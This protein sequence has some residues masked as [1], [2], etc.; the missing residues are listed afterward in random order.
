[1]T[2]S[3][4]MTSVVTSEPK[5]VEAGKTIHSELRCVKTGWEVTGQVCIHHT[6]GQACSY[7]TALVKNVESACLGLYVSQMDVLYNFNI[8]LQKEQ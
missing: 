6:M 5:V 2:F 1:M 4:L 3:Y 8:T 7:I